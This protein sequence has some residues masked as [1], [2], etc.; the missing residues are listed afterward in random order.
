[1]RRQRTA[2]RLLI[3]GAQSGGA[4]E[5]DVPAN[6]PDWSAADTSV[7]RVPTQAREL[8]LESVLHGY[9]LIEHPADM[10]QR[11]HAIT[12]DRLERNRRKLPAQEWRISGK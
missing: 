5:G 11:R 3:C 7:G 4:R 8:A 1:M 12:D 6:N 9:W 10:S 2:Q